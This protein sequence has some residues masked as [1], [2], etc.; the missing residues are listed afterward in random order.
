MKPGLLLACCMC[1]IVLSCQKSKDFSRLQMVEVVYEV[2]TVVDG[3]SVRIGEFYENDGITGME[4]KDWKISGVGKFSKRVRIPKS[5]YADISAVHP[6]SEGWKL[7]IRDRAG[8]LLMG[9]D[10]VTLYHGPPSYYA[11]RIECEVK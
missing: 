6:N 1:L 2:E 11:V 3:L 9:H 7:R 8:K 4:R 5:H 10:A